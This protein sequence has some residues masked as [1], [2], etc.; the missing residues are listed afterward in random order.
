[1]SRW[2]PIFT[3]LGIALIIASSL[4]SPSL[5][6]DHLPDLVV[7]IN[8]PSSAHAGEP[9]G[10]KVTVTVDNLGS[11]TAHGTT[12]DGA[13][14][15]P[16]GYTLEIVLSSDDDAPIRPSVYQSKFREDVQLSGG[17]LS[18]TP[19][20][21]PNYM[22]TLWEAGSHNAHD[23][24][25]PQDTSSGRYFVCAIVDPGKTV[26]EADE[27]NN[28]D[29]ASLSVVGSEPD[30]G[31]IT[32]TPSPSPEPPD[33]STTS[34]NIDEPTP[35]AVPELA[36][37]ITR[38]TVYEDDP[39][40]TVDLSSLLGDEYGPVDWVTVRSNDNPQIVAASV[41][42]GDVVLQ[43]GKDRHGAA[44]IAVD[45]VDE[46]G[47]LFSLS[48]FLDIEP[49]N[50]APVLRTALGETRLQ[51]GDGDFHL[52]LLQVFHDVDLH[53][54]QDRL[55]FKLTND[56]TALLSFSLQDSD[57][58]VHPQPNQHGEAN[59]T[60]TATDQWGLSAMDTLLIVVD[61]PETPV[62]RSETGEPP[63]QIP[64]NEMPSV[65]SD[66]SDDVGDGVA[67]P[68]TLTPNAP[69]QDQQALTPSS[70]STESHSTEEEIT[71]PVP[72]A[73]PEEAIGPM[74][75]IGDEVVPVAAETT[76]ENQTPLDLDEPVDE[77]SPPPSPVIT[78]S[79]TPSAVPLFTSLPPAPA[80]AAPLPSPPTSILHTESA[81]R[82]TPALTPVADPLKAFPSP[83]PAS[84]PSEV[85]PQP[86][87]VTLA[88]TADS[89]SISGPALIALFALASVGALA[90]MAL[91]I[92]IRRR[93]ES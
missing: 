62:M 24:Q 63:A 14:H 18:I 38:L 9:I 90:V 32:E 46:D 57:L 84:V 3:L 42:R 23:L 15:N 52:D 43:F 20:V 17:S 56:N 16:L 53:S 72:T 36:N 4:G 22:L 5:A 85:S 67:G 21:R 73:G 71:N 10:G 66:D 77:P 79:P 59:L 50:D 81:P 55:T 45:G 82:V 65:D 88:P 91:A 69:P 47:F 78:S 27:S 11:V 74:T 41:A 92:R 31:P 44:R 30:P 13:R 29:C 19:D 86:E 8:G 35:L 37:P 39:D 60:I 61:P 70:D 80:S 54:N 58:T 93:A 28:V 1:M 7:D 48:L 2:K 6:S 34:E 25:I 26:D 75:T 33:P 83:F 51:A 87:V 49:A 12:P 76:T 68:E 64:A 40:L 89:P